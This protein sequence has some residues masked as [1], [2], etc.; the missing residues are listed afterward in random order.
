[1][2]INHQAF[3]KDVKQLIREGRDAEAEIRE[4]FKAGVFKPEDFRIRAIA[5]ATMGRG[6]VDACEPALE[7]NVAV[8]QESDGVDSTAFSNIT[9]QIIYS[10]ILDSFVRPEFVGTGLIPT[11]PTRL[12]GEKLPGVS[13]LGDQ[14]AVVNEGMPYPNVGFVEDYINTPE[15]DKRGMIVPVTKEAI[16]FDRTNKVLTE[17]GKVG[18]SL[19]LNKEK[20]IL[21]VILG[22]ASTFATGGKWK[23]KGTEYAVYETNAVDYVSYFYL[24]SIDRI[25]NNYEDLDYVEDLFDQMTDPNISTLESPEPILISGTRTLLVA[26]KLKQTANR[27]INSTETRK[28]STTTIQ[29]LSPPDKM[30]YDIKTSPL[31]RARLA[32][33]KTTSWWVGNFAK[34]FAYMENWPLMVSQAPTNNEAEFTADIV[35]RFK[36]SEKGTPAV[37]APQWVVKSTG[38]GS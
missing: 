34:A 22:E 15:I 18:E 4:Q 32:S 11:Q 9:G 8:I 16:F 24:N 1:M 10:K 7:K 3:A 23:W 19:G 33:N 13:S 38:A 17:A 37:I 2:R 26:P 14:A 29:T 20:R 27:V 30:G 25:F 31:I 36:A 35:A 21:D 12:S 28:G 5:E 6:W